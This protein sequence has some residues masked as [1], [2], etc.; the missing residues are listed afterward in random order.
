M[1]HHYGNGFRRN[2]AGSINNDGLLQRVKVHYRRLSKEAK[3][4]AAAKR[5]D[6]GGESEGLLSADEELLGARECLQ[7]RTLGIIT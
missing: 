6:S 3:D 4:I 5:D 7:Q 2:G 1:V